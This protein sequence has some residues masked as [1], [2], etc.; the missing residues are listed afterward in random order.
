MLLLSVR[1]RCGLVEDEF[2]WD[3]LGITTKQRTVMASDAKPFVP[4][5]L[6]SVGL[7]VFNTLSPSQ[8][9]KENLFRRQKPLEVKKKEG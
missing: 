6:N 1:F 4:M 5:V 9:Y 8:S 3:M 2:K 7:H